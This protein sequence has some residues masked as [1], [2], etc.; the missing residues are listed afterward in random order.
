[1]RKGTARWSSLGVTIMLILTSVG[2]GQRA[3]E[4]ALVL[5]YAGPAAKWV[6]A[7]PIGNGRLGAM[8]FGGIENERIQLNEDTLWAGGPYD[9][10]NPQAL[11][12]LPE[13][14]R[15]IFAGRYR[16]AHDLVDQKMLA[17][18]RGQLPYETVGDL[19]LAF[20]DLGETSDYRRDLNLDTA[21]TSV[22]YKSNGVTYRREA[23]CSPVDQ[24]IVIRLSADRPGRISF[25]ASMA[26]PQKATVRVENGHTLVMQGVNGDAAGIKGALTF[27]ARIRVAADGGEVAEQGDRMSVRGADSAVL[28]NCGCHQLQA[29]Q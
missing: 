6:E 22:T 12:N 3:S 23:F 16:E 9:P 17:H 19:L 7:L 29:L 25:T 2:L 20:P 1:M 21:V 4:D 5:W 8:I 10:N 14:R 11:E 26:T 18:P 27:Q 24:V 28:L 13:A 15:L